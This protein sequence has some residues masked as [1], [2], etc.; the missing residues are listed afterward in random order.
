MREGVAALLALDDDLELVATCASYDELMA[1]VER[2]RPDVVLTDIRMPPTQ[3]DEGIRAANIIRSDYP[4]IG[5]VVLSQYVEPDYAVSLLEAGSARRAYLLKERVADLDELS[6]AIRKVAEGGSVIDPKV[7]DV[8]IEARTRDGASVLDGLT[9]RELEVLAEMAKGAS[10]AA[11][12][13][14]LYISP[15]SV[16]KHISALFTK[17]DLAPVDDTHRRV[18]AVLLYL[19]AGTSG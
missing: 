12:G 7:V 3:T 16:E 2:D 1:A 5:V 6:A 10:N 11:I 8:L 14:A 9:E 18:R 13:E 15:R 17:L 19:G 4:E